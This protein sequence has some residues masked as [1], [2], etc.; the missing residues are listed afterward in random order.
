MTFGKA[1]AAFISAW[2]ISQFTYLQLEFFQYN[3]FSDGQFVWA[4]LFKFVLDV[5]LFVILYVGMY[6]LI[7]FIQSW[8]MR[9][10]YEAGQKERAKEKKS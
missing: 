5:L 4:A 6:Y 8:R 10:R 2:L 1:V 9:A 3:L 7:S